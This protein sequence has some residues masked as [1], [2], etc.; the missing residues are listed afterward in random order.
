MGLAEHRHH[1]FL[2]LRD[3]FLEE[4]TPDK[5]RENPHIHNLA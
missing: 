2:K 3:S 4:E 1:P 5:T